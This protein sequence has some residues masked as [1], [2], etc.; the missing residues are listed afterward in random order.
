MLAAKSA[1]YST[2]DD[3]LHNF[4]RS[5][6]LVNE[7]GA[8]SS[9]AAKECAAFLRKHLISIFDLVEQPERITQHMI[10]E[11][12]GDAVNY[13]ILLEAIMTEG[14]AEKRLIE[15]NRVNLKVV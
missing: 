5:A 10:D 3:K 6:E 7:S 1:E 13:L 4:K 15:S 11:K 12:I 8:A 9:T 14:L 2:D